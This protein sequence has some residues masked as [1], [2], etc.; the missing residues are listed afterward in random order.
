MLLPKQ[1]YERGTKRCRLHMAKVAQL[2]CVICFAPPQSV[3][4][5]CIHGRHSQRRAA[6][7][8]TIPLCFECHDSLHRHP[9]A[10]KRAHGEDHT[11]LPRV[12]EMLRQMEERT[13]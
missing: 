6:D 12:A 11:Y 10:W 13:I 9:T 1:K 2:P 3:V 8:E 5:H 7:T 4:H